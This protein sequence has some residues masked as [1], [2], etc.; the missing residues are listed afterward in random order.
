MRTEPDWGPPSRE[1][2]DFGGEEVVADLDVLVGPAGITFGNRGN[3]IAAPLYGKA[4]RHGHGVPRS[5]HAQ[6]TVGRGPTTRTGP[7][8]ST[9]TPCQYA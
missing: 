4:R 3:L 8:S 5:R 1:S 6:A 9:A 7:S 2:W